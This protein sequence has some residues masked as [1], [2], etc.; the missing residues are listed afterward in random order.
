MPQLD[1]LS[2]CP[3]CG[4]PLDADDEFCGNCGQHLRTP[5]PMTARPAARRPT[6]PEAGGAGAQG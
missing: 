6:A 1:Q 2:A 3:G 4:E 5:P